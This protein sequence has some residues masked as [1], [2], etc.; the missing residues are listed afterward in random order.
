MKHVR[1]FEEFINEQE[2][3]DEARYI[4]FSDAYRALGKMWWNGD[5]WDIVEILTDV[6]KDISDKNK[7]KLFKHALDIKTLSDEELKKLQITN[8]Q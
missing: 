4:Q 7:I 8:K 1:L 6:D 5:F 2:T 3:I